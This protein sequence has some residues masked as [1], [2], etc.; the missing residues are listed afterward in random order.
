VWRI[1]HDRRA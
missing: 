1:W